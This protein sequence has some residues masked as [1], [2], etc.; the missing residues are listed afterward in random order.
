[1]KRDTRLRDGTGTVT[2]MRPGRPVDEERMTDEHVA[3]PTGGEGRGTVEGG[4]RQPV[5][6]RPETGT[7]VAQRFEERRHVE[8]GADLEL[9]GCVVL[10]DVA[11]QEQ[12]QRPRPALRRLTQ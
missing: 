5:A 8:V 6:D 9:G 7:G 2:S 1:M 12:S 11:Q 3:G 4:G 10:A